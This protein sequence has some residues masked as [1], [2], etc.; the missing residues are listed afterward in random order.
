M[1]NKALVLEIE[2]IPSKEKSKWKI[3]IPIELME[4]IGSNKQLTAYARLYLLT[5]CSQANGFAMPEKR[6]AELTGMSHATYLRARE[7]LE[8]LGFIEIVTGEKI[9][10]HTRK[11]MES[12]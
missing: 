11:I 1:A 3:I 2:E 8:K 7:L 4:A 10:V 9:I 12:N 6:I 5:V